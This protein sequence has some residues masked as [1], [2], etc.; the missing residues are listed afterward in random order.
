M[1]DY[2]KLVGLPPPKSDEGK[3]RPTQRNFGKTEVKYEVF[4][5]NCQLPTVNCF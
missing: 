4:T 1:Y 3:K 2:D 5:V